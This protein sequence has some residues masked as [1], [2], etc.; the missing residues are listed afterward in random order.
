MASAKNEKNHWGLWRLVITILAAIN[1]FM[2]PVNTP[3]LGAAETPLAAPDL[4]VESVTMTP[5]NPK[6]GDAVDIAVVIKNKGDAAAGGYRI[7]LYVDP[8]DSPPTPTTA[9]TATTFNGL[10]LAPGATSTWTRTGQTINSATPVIYAWVDRD[11]QVAES[12]ENNNLYPPPVQGNP[13]TFEEDD[14]CAEAKEIDTTGSVQDRNLFRTNN[15]DDVDWVKF[16][17]KSGV[18]YIAEA[19]AVGADANLSLELHAT[20]EGSPSFGAGAQ[21]EFT[22]PADGTYLLRV[23]SEKANYG[24]NTSYQLTVKGEDSCPIALEP[25]NSCG[26]PVDLAVGSSAQP[27]NFCQENDVDWLRVQVEAGAKYKIAAANVGNR[28]NAKLSLYPACNAE[29]AATGQQVEY[30]APAAGYIYVK[31]ENSDPKISGLNTEYTVQASLDGPRGCTEDR[32]EQDDTFATAQPLSAGVAPRTYNSC[33]AGDEDWIKVDTVAGET[34]TVETLKLAGKSDTRLCLHDLQGAVVRCDDDSGAGKGS[35]LVLESTVAGTYYFSIKQLDASLAGAESEYSVQA[36]KGRCIADALEPDNTQATAK[37][38]APDGTVQT[39]NI[40]GANDLDWLSFPGNAGTS[41]IIETSNVGPDADTV[42][43]LYDSAGNRLSVNDDHTAGVNSQLALQVTTPGTY[44]VKVQLYNPE[45][46]GAGTEYS[47][48]VRNSASTPTPT[49]PTPSPPATVTPTPAPPT[50]GVRTLILVNR[51]RLVE[52]FDES[53]TATLMSKLEELARHNN[54]RGE[55]LRLDNNAQVAAAYTAWTSDITNIDKA[56]AVADAIRRVIMTYINERSGVEFV[57]LVGDDRALPFRRIPD[58]TPKQSEKTYED[59]DATHPTGAALRGNYILTDDYFVD[60]QPT[61]LQGREMYVPDL[62]TGRLIE[63]PADMIGIINAFLAQPVTTVD[64][65]FVSG[66]DFVIDTAAED[67]KAWRKALGNDTKVSCLIAEKN[68]PAWTKQQFMDLQLRTSPAAFKFQSINGHATHYAEGA[69]GGGGTLG[70]EVLASP[71]DLRGG[72]VYTLACHGGLNVPPTNSKHPVD[73]A[74]AFTRKGANYIG[75]TGYGWGVH[76]AIGLSEKVIRLYTTELLKGQQTTM[77]QALAVAKTNYV[78]Q[79]FKISAFD[80]KVVQQLTFYGL[81]MFQIQMDG[82]LSEPDEEFPGVGF[83]LGEGTLGPD[84]AV[85]TRTVKLNF[86]RVLNPEDPAALDSFD[87]EDGEYLSL[88]GS[89]ATEPG[90]AVQPLHFGNVSSN[91]EVARSVVILGGDYQ[92]QTVEDPLVSTPVNEYVLDGE[93]A[94]PLGNSEAWYPALPTTV[95]SLDDQS[96][97]ITQLGQYNPASQEERLYENLDVDIYYSTA[98]DQ[99]PP[100]INVVGALHDA[101]RNLISVKIGGSD[102]SGIQDVIISYVH[103]TRQQQGTLETVKLSFDSKLQ[104][105]VGSFPGSEHTRFF[106]QM[107]DKAGNLAS[108]TNKGSYYKAAPARD[109]ATCR[110]CLYLPTITR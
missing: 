86:A 85:I 5:A 26:L 77:G 13:D 29:V 33:P 81:P 16:T 55:I 79:D 65:V 67:C 56:N 14:V 27:H 101:Q 88:N 99:V 63:T 10:G 21:I 20:C 74:E 50:T 92:I 80:E 41:Y 24:P 62:A 25:N 94:A 23:S 98:V 93:D 22:A 15:T 84:D 97:L 54:V 64:E 3:V 18:L 39:H 36:I 96:T 72:L 37:P 110:G 75:N 1:L 28:A 76:N 40:C 51:T 108:A 104:K 58:H 49:P 52:L 19:K 47:I 90:E 34:Y 69:A 103:D 60:R 45:L 9:H 82:S 66:Y 7:H 83:D 42:L 46:Y 2:I 102:D 11:N 70:D 43:E 106:V 44:F 12:D 73:L 89:I 71:V 61:A 17:A 30:I 38:I 6:P 107:V 48:N 31:A 109:E 4:I 35:R 95:R 91:G 68:K 53:S 8:A 100:A 32:Y 59:V 78:K 105:W 87:T 57:V